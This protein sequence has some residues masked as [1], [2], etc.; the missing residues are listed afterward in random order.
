[1]R[2]LADLSSAAVAASLSPL[3][4]HR[5]TP[6]PTGGDALGAA[7][8]VHAR[9]SHK[10]LVEPAP[11]GADLEALLGAAAA[12]PD[13]GR[14]RPWRFYLLAGE[15]QD[16]FGAV[17]ADAYRRRCARRGVEPEAAKLA[18]ERTKLARAPLVVVA[19][20][21][22]VEGAVPEIEQ[23]AA[24]A[25]AVQNMLVV[26]TALGY[27]SMWRTGEPAYDPT[28][29]AALGLAPTDTI[30]GFVYLGTPPADDPS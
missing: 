8:A 5:P 7:A 28:V 21:V 17:L 27:G 3:R 9:R 25:A 13:H 26:A 18:K 1:M 14:L 6:P 30:V 15:T 10:R 4:P 20:C 2:A 29:K 19:A 12:A 22:A 23:I 24:T 11:Q 16:A